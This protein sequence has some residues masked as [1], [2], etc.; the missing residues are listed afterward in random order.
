MLFDIK[1]LFSSYTEP[2]HRTLT[3]D[4]SDEDF[5]GYTVLPPV[6]ASFTAQLEGSVMRIDLQIVATAHAECARCLEPFER[7]FTVDRTF[8][9]RDEEWVVDDAEL[10]FMADGK[11]DVRELAFTELV[12]EIPSVLLCS[13]TCEGLC[14]VCGRRKP[15]ACKHETSDAIDDRLLILKQLLT[16]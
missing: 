6:N 3:L 14:P 8:F 10:P 5:P 4:L 16:D 15:C 13:N 11:L 2:V 9:I 1:K 12:L 7:E